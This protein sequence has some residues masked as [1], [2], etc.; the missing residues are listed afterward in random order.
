MCETISNNCNFS[1]LRAQHFSTFKLNPFHIPKNVLIKD[2]FKYG[3][4]PEAVGDNAHQSKCEGCLSPQTTDFS[5]GTTI[6]YYH[7]QVFHKKKSCGSPKSAQQIR[8]EYG[9][10]ISSVL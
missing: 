6:S 1:V 9:S 3:G 10:V 8:I 7:Y 4:P 2:W 5:P